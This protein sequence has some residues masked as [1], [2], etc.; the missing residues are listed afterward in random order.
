MSGMLEVGD[1]LL[2]LNNKTM[3]RLTFDEIMDFIID[4]DAES[5]DLLFRRPKKGANSQARGG[6][7]DKGGGRLAVC[8]SSSPR[9]IAPVV[10]VA[11]LATWRMPM[12]SE[13]EVWKR[14]GMA[15]GGGE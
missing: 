15:R 8:I 4:A 2:S 9:P 10:S 11:P 14:G 12:G 3:S 5:V 6:K 7:V 13:F 1:E